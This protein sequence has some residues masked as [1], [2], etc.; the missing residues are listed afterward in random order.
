MKSL[1][2]VNISYNTGIA[3]F[4]QTADTT[5]DFKLASSVFLKERGYTAEFMAC[6]HPNSG[7]TNGFHFNFSMWDSA[8]Q[9]VFVDTSKETM[10]SE[11]GERFLAGMLEHAP[12]M[13]AFC[14]PS[15][16]CYW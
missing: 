1:I 16:N 15:I 9:N 5:T 10:L 12:A 3:I 2:L 8:G 7:C 11:F 13:T 14:S 6:A 4:T